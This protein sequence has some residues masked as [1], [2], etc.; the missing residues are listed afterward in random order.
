MDRIL[1]KLEHE[2]RIYGEPSCSHCGKRLAMAGAGYLG[3]GPSRYPGTGFRMPCNPRHID[4]CH[5]PEGNP[6]WRRG[7]EIEAV[8]HRVCAGTWRFVREL[9]D[10]REVYRCR[11][12]EDIL[13]LVPVFSQA[14]LT[15]IRAEF[16][17]MGPDNEWYAET[18]ERIETIG[19][20]L[21][22]HPSL[23]AGPKSRSPR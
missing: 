22:G 5:Q 11:G 2:R 17:A 10:G 16:A 21:A 7:P 13:V 3:D 15:R 6:D 12:C 23:Y 19:K 4:C 8:M 18:A 14:G 9:S 20:E 1:A